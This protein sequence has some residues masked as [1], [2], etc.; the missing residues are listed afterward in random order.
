MFKPLDAMPATAPTSCPACG[1]NSVKAVNGAFGGACPFD[2]AP[3]LRLE[4][5]VGTCA[6]CRSGKMV[7]N[8]AGDDAFLCAV[9]RR[10]P[11]VRVERARLL[12]FGTVAG[13]ECAVCHAQY[14]PVASNAA[15]LKQVAEAFG[16][17][18]LLGQTLTFPAWNDASGS[19]GRFAD[20]SNCVARYIERKTATCCSW[21]GQAT[22]TASHKCGQDRRCRRI[23]GRAWHRAQRAIRPRT[24]VQRAKRAGKWMAKPCRLRLC[25]LTRRNWNTLKVGV[26]RRVKA[27]RCTDG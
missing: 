24:G 7:W 23:I 11:V 27:I 13:F 5:P 1:H 9:C 12:G 25:V 4:W 21:L 8:K 3:L 6:V 26:L 10:A 20:C 2:G 17:S 14:A 16:A 15:R 22:H 18:P 19:T